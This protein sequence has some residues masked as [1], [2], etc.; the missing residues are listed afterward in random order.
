MAASL[1]TFPRWTVPTLPLLLLLLELVDL[2]AVV[3]GERVQ[4]L[5]ALRLHLT[6]LS[7]AL[8]HRTERLL[9]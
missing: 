2:L 6:F 9:L 3:D 1:Q 4:V 7:S 5:C 8:T